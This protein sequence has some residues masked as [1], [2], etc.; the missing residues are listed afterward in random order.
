MRNSA[1][2]ALLALGP[3]S[4]HAELWSTMGSRSDST[5]IVAVDTDTLTLSGGLRTGWVHAVM[6]QSDGSV[7]SISSRRVSWKCDAQESALR[8]WVQYDVTT[9]DVKDNG[10]TIE[11]FASPLPGSMFV[12]VMQFACG[13]DMVAKK[14]SAS[15][16]LVKLDVEGIKEFVEFTRDILKAAAAKPDAR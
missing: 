2:I 3:S 8:Q 16:D 15:H 9:V 7:K 11:G 4:A 5:A 13:Y 14:P 1:L 12:S 10:T 6:S